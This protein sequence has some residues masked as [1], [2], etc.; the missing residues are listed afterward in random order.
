MAE[1]RVLLGILVTAVLL[2]LASLYASHASGWR[3]LARLY[4]ARGSFQGRRWT[5]V[6]GSMEGGTTFPGEKVWILRVGANRHGLRLDVSLFFVPIAPPLFIPWSDVSAHYAFMDRVSWEVV[7]LSFARARDIPFR[8]QERL[9]EQI[10]AEV[11]PVFP[12]S[13]PG[14]GEELGRMQP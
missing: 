10:A 7:E 3:K 13:P 1:R 8:I 14:A 4:R 12:W 6:W 9:A 5:A 2:W 11:G